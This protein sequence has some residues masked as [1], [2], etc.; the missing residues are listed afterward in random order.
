MNAPPPLE[1]GR[2]PY[3]ST[4]PGSVPYV[5]YGMFVKL[6]DEA[7]TLNGPGLAPARLMTRTSLEF[8]SSKLSS[9]KATNCA[10]APPSG[11]PASNMSGGP[12]SAGGVR[13]PVSASVAAEADGAA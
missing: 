2:Y 13:N 6:H 8:A 9:P 3:P 10:A 4:G 11:A 1:M 12:A 7:V 5:P